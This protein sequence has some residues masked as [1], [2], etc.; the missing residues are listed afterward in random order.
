MK[1][2]KYSFQKCGL[3]MFLCYM[4]KCK[5]SKPANA[6]KKCSIAKQTSL[7]SM[8]ALSC[9]IVKNCQQ[10]MIGSILISLTTAFSTHCVYI[11]RHIKLLNITQAEPLSKLP[12]LRVRLRFFHKIAL[13]QVL[14]QCWSHMILQGRHDFEPSNKFK[15]K[16]IR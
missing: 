11:N 12:Y 15:I 10:A 6:F 13:E 5:C 2:L 8:H 9:A 14:C 4:S 16:N 7:H 3:K 1:T